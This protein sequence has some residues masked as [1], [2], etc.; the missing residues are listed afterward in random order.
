MKVSFRKTLALSRSL[1]TI[2]SACEGTRA[3]DGIPPGAMGTDSMSQARARPFHRTTPARGGFQAREKK[4]L[5]H[6]SLSNS[7][8]G[9]KGWGGNPAG[10]PPD[11][12]T[13]RGG[14]GD[15]RK[16]LG[17]NPPAASR[18]GH[19]PLILN[20]SIPENQGMIK[21]EEMWIK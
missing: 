10:W 4:L 2:P 19:R 12:L 11:L 6:R 14:G 1:L 15:F 9:G 8:L 3:G 21:S 5:P 17:A 20:F 13:S 16:A 7:S 18:A